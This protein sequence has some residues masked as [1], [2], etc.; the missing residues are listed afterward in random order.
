MCGGTG[1]TVSN[2]T[3]PKD[4]E[5]RLRF[6]IGNFAAEVDDNSTYF[7]KPETWDKYLGLLA[8][9]IERAKQEERERITKELERMKSPKI[10]VLSGDTESSTPEENNAIIL[11]S[12][13]DECIWIVANAHK[14]DIHQP[15]TKEEE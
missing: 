6:I 2:P 7:V 14:M 9:E 15:N 13:I 5:D 11:N 1:E 3:L 10:W 12:L 4:V 8:T